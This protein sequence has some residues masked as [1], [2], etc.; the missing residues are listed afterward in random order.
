MVERVKALRRKYMSGLPGSAHT[1]TNAIFQ[2][3]DVRFLSELAGVDMP[4]TGSIANLQHQGLVLLQ[5]LKLVDSGAEVNIEIDLTKF[6]GYI[7][8]SDIT[9]AMADGKSRLDNRGYGLCRDWYSD[10]SGGLYVDEYYAFY[11][12]NAAYSIRSQHGLAKDSGGTIVLDPIH[13]QTIT[14]DLKPVKVKGHGMYLCAST[15]QAVKC[16]EVTKKKLSWLKSLPAKQVAKQGDGT[17]IGTH[18][19]DVTTANIINALSQRFP[20]VP[21]LLDISEIAMHAEKEAHR[22]GDT[23]YIID[24]VIVLNV[25]KA[26][27]ADADEV[28]DRLTKAHHLDD[29][30]DMSAPPATHQ[31]TYQSVRAQ[32]E[33]LTRQVASSFGS[34][35][36]E[37]E[38]CLNDLSSAAGSSTCLTC[39]YYTH[40]HN[41]G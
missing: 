32:I 19:T 14:T 35:S 36:E 28:L 12:P 33:H 25:Q 5:G 30:I 29:S 22:L 3:D 34:E 18:A 21:N 20:D 26:F 13:E 24:P 10:E 6:V 37:L 40:T 27:R 38:C 39:M 1:S 8:P 4:R 2:Y 7:Q 9:I 11:C 16:V 23:N 41:V 15:G 17:P 31:K